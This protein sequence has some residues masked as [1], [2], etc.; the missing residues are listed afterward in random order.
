MRYLPEII[1]LVAILL[2]IAG[3]GTAYYLWHDL[4]FCVAAAAAALVTA[5]LLLN[6]LT[7]A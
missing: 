5:T 2:G 1:V 7:A 6:R 4:W 3:G